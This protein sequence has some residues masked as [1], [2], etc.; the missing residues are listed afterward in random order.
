MK[1]YYK[2]KG[3]REL[4][5]VEAISYLLG[6]DTSFVN[7]P[8]IDPETGLYPNVSDSRLE[9]FSSHRRKEKRNE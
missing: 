6:T 9:M 5:D 3:F 7:D 2:E 8:T 4:K 1:I